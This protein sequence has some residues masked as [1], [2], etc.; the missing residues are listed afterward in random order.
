[1]LTEEGQGLILNMRIDEKGRDLEQTAAPGD[2]I[3]HL[4]L[5]DFENYAG[6]LSPR[7]SNVQPERPQVD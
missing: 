5:I 3:I 2:F 7:Q 6:S 1:M 4:K